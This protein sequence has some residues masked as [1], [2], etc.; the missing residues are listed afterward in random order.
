MAATTATT[1]EAFAARVG[2]H[3]TMASRLFN[4]QRVPSLELMQRISKEYNISM[5][6]LVD[7]RLQGAQQFAELL[8]SRV[9]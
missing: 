7:A 8:R 3:H 9:G 1:N 5:A 6:A 2:C 4:G